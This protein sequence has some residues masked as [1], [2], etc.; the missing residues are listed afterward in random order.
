LS[1]DQIFFTGI[2]CEAVLLSEISIFSN[3]SKGIN[4]L[5]NQTPVAISFLTDV[6]TGTTPNVQGTL[7]GNPNTDYVI[8]FFKNFNANPSGNHEGEIFVGDDIVT[9]DGTGAANINTVLNESINV[10]EVVTATAKEANANTSE[11]SDGVIAGALPIELISFVAHPIKNYIHLSWL[12]ATEIN[13]KGFYIEK[14]NSQNNWESIAFVNGKGTKLTETQYLLNDKNV[15]INQ[16]YFYRLRQVDFDGRFEY[17]KIV[18]AKINSMRSSVGIF[19]PNP[20]NDFSNLD[21]DSKDD[22]NIVV[23]VFDALGQKVFTKDFYLEKRGQLKLPISN[24][25]PGEFIVRI[26]MDDL[27]FV[28]KFIKS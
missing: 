23:E 26:S 18:S 5:G 25:S 16:Q 17:S 3:G 2:E 14:F 10:N 19:Y 1:D 11:F 4:Y 9:T 24:L 12:T 8:E 22:E 21:F 6:T 20:A 7:N 28:R 27:T 15:M 13:N